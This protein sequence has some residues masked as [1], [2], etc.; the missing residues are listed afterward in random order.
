MA[1]LS[2]LDAVRRKILHVFAPWLGSFYGNPSRRIAWAGTFG[3]VFA[4]AL[5]LRFPLALLALGPLVLGVP[6]LLSDVRYLIVKPGAHRRPLIVL[7]V[8]LPLAAT[9]L[10]P[11][12]E[13]GLLALVGATLAARTNLFR[14]AIA[15]G[16][17]SALYAAAFTLPATFSLVFAHAHNFIAAVVLL[18]F[19]RSLRHALAPAIVFA[20]LSIVMLSGGFDG[21]SQHA[22]ASALRTGTDLR[23]AMWQYAPFCPNE[24]TAIR[25]VV[26]F[27]FAQSVHYS[28]WLRLV[29]DEARPRKGLPSFS[30]S[31][32]ALRDDFGRLVL[33]GFALAS[34]T[35]L[36]WGARD[37]EPA[38]L[39]Y[40]RFAAFHGYLELA[41]LALL[42]L[43]GRE[44]WI[45]SLQP[46][47]ATSEPKGAI[48]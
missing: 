43:E 3:I 47:A 33:A 21:F 9:W 27:V 31:F 2:S 38:R 30:R 32:R 15:F 1:L 24:T 26:L 8:L 11:K 39:G 12:L 16:V 7:L 41:F 5:S 17:V 34:T 45:P 42:V 46:R 14:K 44:Q 40:L 4:L 22:A 18:C 6:H 36:V 37:L 13:V 35:F 23:Q 28:I 48:A 25:F 20:V 10:F 19:S 29:P